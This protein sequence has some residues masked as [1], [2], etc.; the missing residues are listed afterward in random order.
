[1][2]VVPLL[3]GFDAVVPLVVDVP[4]PVVSAITVSLLGD[5]K[6]ITSK[7]VR[8]KSTTEHMFVNPSAPGVTAAARC[9]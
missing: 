6:D 3:A 9:R 8:Q 1:L 7:F 2:R 4:V 5:S